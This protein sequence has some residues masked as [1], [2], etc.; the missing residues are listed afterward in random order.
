MDT[1]AKIA[2]PG[3]PP[4]LRPGTR[5]VSGFFDPLL[6]EH[7]DQLAAL[8]AGCAALA[9]VVAEPTEPLLPAR[10]RAELVAALATV[11]AVFLADAGAPP[12]DLHLEEAHERLRT[13]F[14]RHVRERQS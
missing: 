8:R 13:A 7:A 12:A 2:A 5:V 11:D 3:Q 1:R 4:A 6:R 9:V 10:A 14:L